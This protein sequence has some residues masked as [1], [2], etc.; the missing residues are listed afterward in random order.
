MKVAS[1]ALLTTVGVL[2]QATLAPRP[3]VPLDPISTPIQT[4]LT[5]VQSDVATWATPSLARLRGTVIGAKEFV[6][7][8]PNPRITTDPLR[9]EDQIDAVLYLGSPTTMTSSM[10][11]AAL[12]ADEQYLSMRVAR[13]QLDPGPPGSPPPRD[14]LRRNC[15]TK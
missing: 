10:L 1:L 2:S 13:M 5:Q 8:F 11:P 4:D 7:F 9:Y 6:Y 14:R 3:A 12:C 15:A